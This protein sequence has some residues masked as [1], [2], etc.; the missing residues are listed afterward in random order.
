MAKGDEQAEKLVVAHYLVHKRA[1]LS[2][3]SI[4][5]EHIASP[6]L[7]A[8][9]ERAAA[10]S[11]WVV[12]DLGLSDA[13][14]GALAQLEA[15]DSELPELETRMRRA[16]SAR[17]A[18]VATQRFLDAVRQHGAAALESH[19][20][21]L[22]RALAEAEGGAPVASQPHPQLAYAKLKSWAEAIA[23][24]EPDHLLPLPL[25]TLNKALGGY[26]DSKTYLIFGRSSEH[27]TT[28]ARQSAESIARYL[29]EIG[30]DGYVVYWTAEDCNE[31]IAS[32]TMAANSALDTH[33]LSTGR[34]PDGKR[35]EF[36]L[37]RLMCSAGKHIEDP[38]LLHLRYIDDPQPRLSR[39]LSVARA[40][41]AAGM[42][43]FFFDF[44]QLIEPDVGKYKDAGW[45][46]LLASTL[47]RLAKELEIPIVCVAQ[48]S[49]S[50][51]RD[52]EAGKGRAPRASDIM[53]GLSWKQCCYGA[54][55]VW[56]DNDRNERI[57][58]NIEKWKSGQPGHLWY[59]VD[60]SHDRIIDEPVT[61]SHRKGGRQRS[62]E[63]HGHT[64]NMASSTLK[65]ACATQ[66][67]SGP[68]RNKTATDPTCIA[69]QPVTQAR[70]EEAHKAPAS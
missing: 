40:E 53:G 30:S 36:G 13:Q 16:W 3:A 70:R 26:V 57:G 6:R 47:Q 61:P 60:P 21:E 2:S 18:E 25:D 56:K 68:D 34:L 14:W 20:H 11:S 63:F 37:E 1:P 27:K 23:K 38:A 7:R 22:R 45:W 15:L 17:R 46:S 10:R 67:H 41:R 32:R 24:P 29:Q 19:T 31:D 65:P 9:W 33:T 44:V 50:P 48:L 55:A 58:I 35:T 54:I 49:T 4:G 8:A 64:K 62:G 51:T 12:A 42:R 52:S 43:A 69:E 59:P 5:F 39:V 28:F 66:Q